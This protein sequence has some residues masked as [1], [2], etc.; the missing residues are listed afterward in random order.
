MYGTWWYLDSKPVVPGESF[1]FLRTDLE[2][3]LRKRLVERLNVEII[4]DAQVT[5]Y[6]HRDERIYGVEYINAEKQTIKLE[7]DLVVE[8]GG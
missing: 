5:G 7:A 8:C 4:F 6:L 3:E 1:S 2:F